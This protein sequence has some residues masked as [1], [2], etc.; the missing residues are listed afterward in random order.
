QPLFKIIFGPEWEVAGKYTAILAPFILLQ[1]TSNPL[2]QVLNITGSQRI[3]LLINV[4]RIL[5]L[6]ALFFVFKDYETSPVNFVIFFSA[7]LCVYYLGMTAFIFLTVNKSSAE[8][9]KT[10]V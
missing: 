4:I 5:G 10:A 3:F 1:F 2:M 7:Y 8:Q 9:N 6:I